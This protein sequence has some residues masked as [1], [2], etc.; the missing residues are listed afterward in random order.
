MASEKASQELRNNE[1]PSGV[2]V[3]QRMLPLV[4]DIN[5]IHSDLLDQIRAFIIDE[6]REIEKAV[7]NGQG[8]MTMF[9]GLANDGEIEIPDN[10]ADEIIEAVN[11]RFSSNLVQLTR[12]RD[13]EG[14]DIVKLGKKTEKKDPQ[15]ELS[16]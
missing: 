16:G 13:E 10:E 9:P 12:G 15:A 8:Q 7:A 2:Q 1:R 11:A 3:I 4:E 5:H 14:N 6:R